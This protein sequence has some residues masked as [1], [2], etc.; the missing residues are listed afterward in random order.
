MAQAGIRADPRHFVNYYESQAGFALPGFYRA[1][2]MY[3]RGIGSIFS[4]L[5][6]FVSPLLKKDFANAKPHLKSAATNIAS[7]VINRAVGNL[8]NKQQNQEGSGGIMVLSHRPRRHPSGK[9]LSTKSREWKKSLL[10]TLK[11][12]D[13]S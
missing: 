1:P 4:R 11:F 7:D 2:V 13:Q 10:G 8:V 12:F 9:C 3:G 6:R 5:F